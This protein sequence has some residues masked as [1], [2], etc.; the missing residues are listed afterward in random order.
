MCFSASASFTASAV[1]SLIG[2][3][4]LN[5]VK[6]RSHY[7]FAAIPFLFGIQQFSEGMVWNALKTEQNAS[8]PILAFLFFAF[9]V[10]PIWVPASLYL[11]ETNP[12]RKK[13][14][15]GCLGFGLLVVSSISYSWFF[16]YP[17]AI[18]ESCHILYL[19]QIS[20]TNWLLG[21]IAYLIATIAPFFLCSN[22]AFW[23]MGAVLATS[24]AVSYLFYYQYLISVWCFFAAVLSILIVALL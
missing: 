24:Y 12:M 21:T 9:I 4:S 10:W 5:R 7:L 1:L 6:K 8:I 16:E 17:T 20:S 2:L 13:L 18:I 11:V 22:H 3:V 15:L 19:V 14:I 23:W